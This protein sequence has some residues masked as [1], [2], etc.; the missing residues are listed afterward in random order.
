[1]Q[2]LLFAFFIISSNSLLAQKIEFSIQ[3][4]AGPFHYVGSSAI[5]ETFYFIDDAPYGK[6]NASLPGKIPGFS[7]SIEAG[8]KR[9]SKK[10]WIQGVGV[11]FESLKSKCNINRVVGLGGSSEVSGSNEAT[12]KYI[13]VNP[14]F[15]KRI[16]TKKILLDIAMGIDF[17]FG[18][19]SYQEGQFQGNIGNPYFYKVDATKPETDI[20]L[21]FQLT[22]FY[23]KFG[24]LIGYS[25]GLTNYYRKPGWPGSEAFSRFLRMGISYRIK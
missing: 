4:Q 10:Q 2:K 8:A 3:P 9:V 23:K 17:A 12:N 14:Y 1:M 20:K 7:Y 15:G 16:G 6:V 24:L 22:T 21:R 5:K 11:S 13:T 25:Y 18:L 19:S